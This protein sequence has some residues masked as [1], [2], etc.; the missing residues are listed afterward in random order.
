MSSKPAW[1][2]Q[3]DP[4][5][6]NNNNKTTAIGKMRKHAC[7]PKILHDNKNLVGDKELERI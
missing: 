7:V 1:I 4:V 5:K 6:K 2:T 3:K